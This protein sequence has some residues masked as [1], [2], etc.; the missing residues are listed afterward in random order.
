MGK[1]LNDLGEYEKAIQHFDMGNRL[2]HRRMSFDRA[3]HALVVDRLIAKFTADFFS[4][5][6][7]LGSDWQAPVLILGMPRSGTTL[8]EQILSNHP[9]VA[10]GGELTFLGKMRGE[11]PRGCNWRHRSGVDQRSGM[12]LSSAAYQYFADRAADRR[13]K[14]E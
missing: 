13:Q 9:Q 14:A 10:A 12:R 4:R 5:N 8:V 7:A 11:L 1:A 6:A 3:L 2:K